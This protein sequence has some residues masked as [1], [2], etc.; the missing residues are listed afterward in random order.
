ME[1]ALCACVICNEFQFI[2]LVGAGQG[3]RSEVDPVQ[4][5]TRDLIESCPLKQ[6]INIPGVNSEAI[7]ASRFRIRMQGDLVGFVESKFLDLHR[8][9]PGGGLLEWNFDFKFLGLRILPF[10]RYDLSLL[11]LESHFAYA[12]SILGLEMQRV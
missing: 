5:K 6:A 8:H 11:V 1:L 12:A 10:R 9:P 7:E 4:V 3:V 2:L